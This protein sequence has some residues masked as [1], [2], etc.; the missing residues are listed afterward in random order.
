MNMKNLFISTAGLV[1]AAF[2]G[3]MPAQA[4]GDGGSGTSPMVMPQDDPCA[5]LDAARRASGSRCKTGIADP[6]SQYVQPNPDGRRFPGTNRDVGVTKYPDGA[7]VTQKAGRGGRP[8]FVFRFSGGR[9]VAGYGTVSKDSSTGET[10]WVITTST[11]RQQKFF[12]LPGGT[13]TGG[14]GTAA[15][16]TR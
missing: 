6:G 5:I 2:L 16:R 9:Q 12:A 15:Q 4:G 13:I 1:L 14:V 7:S 8:Y 10:V 3:V 11:G